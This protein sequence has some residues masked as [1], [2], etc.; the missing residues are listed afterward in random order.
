MKL[1]PSTAALRV[2]GALVALVTAT[3]VAAPAPAYPGGGSTPVTACGQTLTDGAHHLTGDLAC[4]G[5]GFTVVGVVT[6]D[7]AGH[8]LDGGGSGTAFWLPLPWETEDRGTLTVTGGRVSGWSTGFHA[9]PSGLSWNLRLEACELADTDVVFTANDWGGP[10]VVD[11]CSVHDNGA[12]FALGMTSTVR[13]TDSVLE[14]NA[15][16]VGFLGD[17]TNVSIHRSTLV[18]N[19]RFAA[20]SAMASLFLSE[21]TISGAD[22]ALEGAIWF[23]LVVVGNTFLG[24]GTA[25]DAGSGEGT[26]RENVFEDNG[27]AFTASGSAPEPWGGATL[28]TD[29]RFERNGDAIVVTDGA[30]TELGG[31]VVL[32]NTGWGIYAPGAVDLGGNVA[33]GNGRS[34][35][36]TGVVCTRPRS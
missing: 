9:D 8:T 27:T 34:P 36:C 16:V 28:L 21:S 4:D 31:N 1:R 15:E 23:G 3:V 13:V 17:G 2:L 29:N 26:F 6:L 18:D 22:L 24:N 12:V 20:V 11:G 14:R 10:L 35:Q 32:G 7:L 30:Q 5:V 19:G 33:Y 25:I